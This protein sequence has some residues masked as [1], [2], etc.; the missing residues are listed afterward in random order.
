LQAP[1]FADG[2][3][4]GVR[5][6]DLTSVIMGPFATHI[7][8]DMGA[9]VIKIESPEGDSLRHYEPLRHAGMSGNILNLHRNKR[10]IVLDLKRP[11]CRAALDRLIAT[12][13]VFVHNLR[14]KAIA[15]L[16]YDYERVRSLKPDIVYCGAYGF[17]AQGPYADKPAYDDLIQAGSGVAGLFAEVHGEPA[18][19]P[20][21]ICDKLAGQAIAY[22]VLGALYQ[23]ARGGGGQAIEV[24]MLE[25]TIEFNLAEHMF[26]SAFEPPLSRPGFKRLLTRSRKP[27]R[28]Q[29]GYA[30]ILPYSDQN[31][32]DFYEFTGRLEFKTDPR[33]KRLSDRVQNIAVLYQMIEEEA[34]RRPT[35]QW[36]AFCDRANIPCM[37]VLSL[38]TVADDPHVKAVGLFGSDEHP[39]EGRYR[40][41]RRPVSFSR[42]P[43]RVRRHA[44]R[45]GEHTR[46]VLEEA[47]LSPQEIDRVIAASAGKENQ[48][49]E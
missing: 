45:L 20:T 9:D 8:A 41:V 35:A 23:V 49:E 43:F 2:P 4:S 40:V 38:D 26:G 1:N 10:G 34:P 32:Q 6:L 36:V 19:V 14:A 46:S 18:Y 21:V 7:L 13:D 11:E 30:C 39:S 15:R 31:W 29:D 16:G 17:G 3:L 48:K 33:F 5:V 27:Y 47:G 25:T 42:A 12:A 28:T 24:P 22:S 44:P 37:P